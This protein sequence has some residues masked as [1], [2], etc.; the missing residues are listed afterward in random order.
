MIIMNEIIR[1]FLIV[2]SKIYW[3]YS[4]WHWQ[5]KAI[6]QVNYGGILRKYQLPVSI[7]LKC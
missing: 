7:Y 2:Q 3:R 6:G 5:Y 1:S 4:L